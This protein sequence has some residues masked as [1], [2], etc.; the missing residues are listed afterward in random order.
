MV[1]PISANTGSQPYVPATIDL[2]RPASIPEPATKVTAVEKSLGSHDAGKA[3]QQDLQ[4]GE[5]SPGLEQALEQINNSMKAWATGMQFSIDPEIQ[6]V[7]VSI[8]DNATGEVLRTVPSDAVIRVAK[9]I[10]QLQGMAVNTK[11]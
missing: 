7:V 1:D 10:A 6:R 11:A 9:T 4:Q 3:S 5:N 2:Q 8:V